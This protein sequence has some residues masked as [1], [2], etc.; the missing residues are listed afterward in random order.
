MAGTIV[1]DP[2]NRK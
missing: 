1:A 2:D